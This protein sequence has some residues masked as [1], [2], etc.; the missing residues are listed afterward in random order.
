MPG[1][2][3][4]GLKEI[5]GSEIKPSNRNSVKIKPLKS[6]P[7]NNSPRIG[8]FFKILFIVFAGT[9]WPWISIVS[10]FLSIKPEKLSA[11]VSP[12]ALIEFKYSTP[13]L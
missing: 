3:E 4:R 13:F 1:A 11:N 6:F 2:D 9:N 7:V 12:K 5:I 8:I 10:L